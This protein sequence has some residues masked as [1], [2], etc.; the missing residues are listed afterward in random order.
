MQKVR[1]YAFPYGHS[2]PTDCRHA[3]SES[4]SLP[5]RGSFHLSLT[6]L[7]AIGVW[8]YL[9]L[10][11]GAPRFPQGV[12][13]PVVLGKLLELVKISFT[14]LSPTMAGFSKPFNYLN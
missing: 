5:F 1:G 2:A 3:V 7:Y 13:D 6:V 9:A 4:I 10:D 14:G 8:Q 11:D 12:S